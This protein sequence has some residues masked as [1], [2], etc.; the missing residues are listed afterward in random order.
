MD[1]N[2]QARRFEERDR[3]LQE[4]ADAGIADIEGAGAELVTEWVVE[5]MKEEI[6]KFRKL[7]AADKE[8]H[9]TIPGHG[10]IKPTMIESDGSQVLIIRGEVENVGK[11]T[12]IMNISQINFALVE[13]P[14]KDSK[15]QKI[16][17]GFRGNIQEV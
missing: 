2:E 8:V 17:I 6:T 10:R 3:R 12:I 14:G 9:L 15:K 5:V 11:S 4:L 7:I 16:P 13:A 1:I